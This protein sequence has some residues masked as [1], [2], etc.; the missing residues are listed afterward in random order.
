MGDGGVPT[1]RWYYGL[2][3]GRSQGLVR[4]VNFVKLLPSLGYFWML[5]SDF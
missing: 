5:A 1:Y 4:L 3:L 2:V